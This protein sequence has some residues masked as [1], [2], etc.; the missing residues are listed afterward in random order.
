MTP[1]LT[2]QAS[3]ETI[4]SRDQPQ[5]SQ[6]QDYLRAFYPFHPELDDDSSTVTLP[7]NQGD[8]VFVHSVQPNGWADGT[9]LMSGAR[10]WL[11]TNYCVAYDHE[12]MSRLM[13]ALTTFWDLIYRSGDEGRLVFLNGDY[14]RGLVA[15]VRYLLV[16]LTAELRRQHHVFSLR[17]PVTDNLADANE[18]LDERG[19]SGGIEQEF[20]AQS[21]GPSDRP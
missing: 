5:Q 12:P 17:M 4:S 3:V 19:S 1:P 6:F 11:P 16:S 13:R 2:P 14:M 8:L 7:L 10:G 15:G 21:Q 18:L 9:L 20:T